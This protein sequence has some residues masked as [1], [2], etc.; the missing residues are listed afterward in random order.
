MKSQQ[1]R[2]PAKKPRPKMSD[3]NNDNVIDISGYG[4]AQPYDTMTYSSGIDTIDLNSLTTPSIS[5]ITLPNTITYSPGATVGG[6]GQVLSSSGNAVNWTSGTTGY[7]NGYSINS[8]AY[9]ISP[10]TVNI[11]AGGVEMA[12]GTDIKIG[13]QSLKEFMAKMEQRLSILVPDPKKLEKFE[14]LKKAYEHYKTLESLCFDE[15]EEEK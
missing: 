1:K 8:S 11:N 13:G 3:D 5:T 2:T 12:E 14:A 4:A 9:G 6:V 7:T 15:P 10:N